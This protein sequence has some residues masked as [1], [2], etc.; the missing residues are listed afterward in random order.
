MCAAPSQQLG[1]GREV[2]RE[3]GANSVGWRVAR[4]S[5]QFFDFPV[6]FPSRGACRRDQTIVRLAQ[7]Q[8][9]LELFPSLGRH[10]AWLKDLGRARAIWTPM[11]P[12]REDTL[13]WALP[14]QQPVQKSP[15]LKLAPGAMQEEIPTQVIL[16]FLYSSET[17]H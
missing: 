14:P 3:R 13:L 5:H 12:Q 9:V 7:A 15:L 1:L 11:L 10:C 16:A 6:W 17:L 4:R 8:E 2:G